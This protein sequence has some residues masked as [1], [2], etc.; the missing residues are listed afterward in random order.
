MIDMTHNM[1]NTE[2]E[3][4]NDKLGYGKLFIMMVLDPDCEIYIVSQALLT[5]HLTGLYLS[6][7]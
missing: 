6:A 3:N 7:E 4:K 5:V 1:Q 2:I